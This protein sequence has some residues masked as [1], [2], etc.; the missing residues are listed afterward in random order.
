MS[1]TTTLK[2]RSQPTPEWIESIR[3][4]YPVE[5]TL[6][7]VLTKKLVNRTQ[8]GA[9][10]TDFNELETRLINYVK[11]VSGQ[12]DAVIKNLKRLTG[13][14]SKEQ[15][16]FDLTWNRTAGED[17]CGER[18]TR[19]LILR[20][21]PAESVV[22]TH[23]LREAQVLRAMW[24]EV[25]VP[26]IFWVD[27]TA[28]SLGH[29]FLIANFLEGT[30]QPEDGGKVT[31][32]GMYFE[33]GLREALKDQ[34]VRHLAAIHTVDWRRKDL[35][36]YDKP[37][38]GTTEA[39]EWSLGLWERI[40]QEDTL[41]AHPV[42][43]QAAI[44]LKENMPMVENPVIVH[45]DY[46]SGNFMYDD[47]QQINAILDWELCHLGDF[48]EDLAY[49]RCKMLGTPDGDGGVRCSGLMYFDEF[50]EKYQTLTG[51]TVDHKLLTWYDIFTHYKV[52]SISCTALRV[53]HE[54]KT[55]LDAMMNIIGGL[56]FIGT[57]ELQRL[58]EKL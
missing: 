2:L 37:K 42:M 48:H 7:E 17:P 50:V 51:Y 33:P 32:L 13:G 34:F 35:S 55:H 22:E 16:T 46:R 5:K 14:A 40:W 15:F 25:P 52:G 47:D 31:G 54:N 11:S 12:D 23:R 21:D 30:V 49:N 3:T 57:S 44:W 56:G 41:E 10:K 20:M 38:P 19:K 29:P 9:H 18:E 4:T 1:Q 58:L 8:T 39:N 27:H 36:T 28:E 26:E 6:D 53:A 43:E 45:G 24:G